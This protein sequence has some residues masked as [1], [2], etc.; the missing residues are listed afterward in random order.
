MD[1]NFGLRVDGTPKGTG[2]LGIIPMTDGSNRVMTEQSVG[3]NYGDK[4]VQVPLINPYMTREEI[5]HLANGGKPT[6]EMIRKTGEWG[7]NRLQQDISPFITPAE[8][9]NNLDERY[10]RIILGR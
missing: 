3:F 7:F 4:E 9:Q 10:R 8:Q 6:E 1:N 2:F 5:T